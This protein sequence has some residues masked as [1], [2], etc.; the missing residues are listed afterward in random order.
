MSTYT[1]LTWPVQDVA[2]VCALQT[3]PAGTL[4]LNGTLKNDSIPNQIAF[5]RVNMIRNVSISSVNNLSGVNFI[6]EGF[7]NQAYITETIGPAGIV[8][9]PNNNTVYGNEFFDIITRVSVSNTVTAVSVGTGRIG[10]LPLLVINSNATAINYS[11]TVL[12][13]NTSINYSVLQTLDQ[14]LNNFITLKN[15]LPQFFPCLGMTNKSLSDFAN[16]TS[17]SNFVLLQINSATNP[18]P[19]KDSFNFIFLQQ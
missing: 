11:A 18:D 5:S 16:S 4:D 17:I 10:F 13:S 15:Q 2:A 7:Q 14:V 9:S 1:K 3:K 12:L 19:A 6:V 8:P